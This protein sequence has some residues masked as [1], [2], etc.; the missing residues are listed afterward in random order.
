MTQAL[1]HFKTRLYLLT[2]GIILLCVGTPKVMTA[3]PFPIQFIP[4]QTEEESDPRDRPRGGGSRP[5]C[6]RDLSPDLTCSNAKMIALFPGGDRTQRAWGLTQSATPSIW[7]FSPYS[8]TTQ[9]TGAIDI[10]DEND[11]VI[12]HQDG[13]KLPPNPSFFAVSIPEAANLQP[14]QTYRWYFRV[15]LDPEQPSASALLSGPD[16]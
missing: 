10:V 13:I 7:F 14:R 15:L 5:I 6:S 8:I 12:W 9:V 1:F 11:A 16:G 4:P 3:N 2:W